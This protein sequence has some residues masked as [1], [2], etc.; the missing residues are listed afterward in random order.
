[1][2]NIIYFEPCKCRPQI[3]PAQKTRNQLMKLTSNKYIISLLL[4]EHLPRE[5][6]CPFMS[7]VP[8]CSY[9]LHSHYWQR[10]A[11]TMDE[12][13]SRVQGT[14]HP[15]ASLA[16][17][18]APPSP[19]LLS[20]LSPPSVVGTSRDYSYKYVYE[21]PLG[22]VELY[23]NVLVGSMEAFLNATNYEVVVLGRRVSVFVGN[24]NRSYIAELSKA[25]HE[26][27]IK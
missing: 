3:R 21:V 23:G 4:R 22:P 26:T 14:A 10:G 9:L 13:T 1:M 7:E 18:P 27:H 12:Y 25:G 24:N 2:L 19:P 15:Y 5:Y 11:H 17:S 8:M 16:T 20:T 6:L